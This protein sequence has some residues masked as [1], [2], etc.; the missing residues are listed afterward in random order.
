MAESQNIA[1]GRYL[2][3]LRERRKFSLQDVSSLSQVFAETLNKGYL[4][5]CENGRQRLAFSKVIPLSRIYRVPGDVFLERWELDQEL[6]RVGAPDTE[7]M[8]FADLTKSGTEA[9]NKGDYWRSYAFLRDAVVRATIDPVK[10]AFRD[11]A[12][13]YN[14]SQMNC[15]SAALDLGKNRFALH[16]FR[17]ARDSKHFG[18]RFSLLVLERL[19][20]VYREL[21]QHD[22]AREYADSAVSGAES[23]GESEYLGFFYA[24]R[25][26]LA[27]TDSDFELAASNYKKA[28][29][30]FSDS[31]RPEGCA[32][33]LNNLAQVF[34]NLGR[35]KAARRAL[36]AAARILA[37]C[38]QHRSRA[39]GHI[40]LGEIELLEDHGERAEKHWLE[41]A[42]VAKT[43]NDKTLRFKAEVLLLKQA[44][45]VGKL[46][47]ARS[48]HR[49]LR[50]LANWVP[51]NTPELKEFRELASQIAV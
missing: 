40:L 34:Y 25:G 22:L 9:L 1:F 49:R 2:R 17:H 37:P 23:S 21:N 43:L 27:L 7:G 3:T 10:P 46:D 4:S 45:D 26:I 8:S 28:Y 36:E 31:G 32:K 48:I 14:C 6:D 47:V 41:A 12:E 13:Q 11:T 38:G 16:E 5:R 24:N 15:A 51:D 33:S 35:Y 44:C 18:S 39:L 29:K 19:S 50:K 20:R 42:K 30:S